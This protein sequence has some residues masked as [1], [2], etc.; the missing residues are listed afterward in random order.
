MSEKHTLCAAL[1]TE[2]R[3]AMVRDFPNV[4]VP[5]ECP[6]EIHKLIVSN[7]NWMLDLSDVRQTLKPF[8]NCVFNDNGDV[9]ID[10]SHLTK[11]DWL[12]ACRVSRNG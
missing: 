4:K 3:E 5:V 11:A 2:I 6:P 12:A 7:A 10:Q 1:W 9:T 8:S